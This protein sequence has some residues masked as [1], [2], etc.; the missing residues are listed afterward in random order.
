MQK[1]LVFSF[2]F[3]SLTV[4][5]VTEPRVNLN[6][7]EGLFKLGEFYQ[8]QDRYEEAITQYKAIAS[9][10][11]YSKLATEGE[12][13]VAD[14]YYKK[15]EYIEAFNAYKTFKELHPKHPQIDYVTYYAAESIR[16]QLPSTVDRDLS[17]ASQA[18]NYYE[19]IVTAYPNS[20][21]AADSKEKRFKLIGMLADKEIYIADFYYGREKYVGAL[22]RYDL[23]LQ[24]F[25]QSPKV[26]H[27]LLGAARSAKY[28]EIPDKVAP[29]IARLMQDHP[30]TSEAKTAKSEFP[31][32]AR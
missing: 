4:G 19:E 26:P 14:C 18:I 32:A 25:P 3:L 29:Y 28:A 22:T 13:R 12:L 21:Y 20:K 30:A 24:M 23:F 8:K 9:K 16:Q 31:N 27:A 11:P 2:L 15:E 10:H 17:Q 5:C 1:L 7:P 6:T